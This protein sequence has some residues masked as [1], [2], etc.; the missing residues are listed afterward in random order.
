MN[1]SNEDDRDRAGDARCVLGAGRERPEGAEYRGVEG[2]AE[3][4]PH[5]GP[6]DDAAAHRGDVEGVGE[7]RGHEGDDRRR[8]DLDEPEQADA[9]DLAGEQVAGGHAGEEDLDGAA[10]LLLDDAAEDHGAVGADGE[11]QHHRH[12]EGGGLVVGAAALD[13]AELDVDDRHGLDDG[14]QLLGVH[15]GGLGP[16]ADSDELD[17]T[18]HDRLEL[19]VGARAPVE[20]PCIDH[21]HV[22]VA[23]AYGGSAVG[24]CV[25]VVD[26]DCGVDGVTL[27]LHGAGESRR[28]C[29]G[30]PDVFGAGAGA[31]HGGQ[32]D[33]GGDRQ[34]HH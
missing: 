26:A 17:G 19:L 34:E 7:R 5:D 8:G 27:G 13:L 18:G 25:V 2:V 32:G 22:D 14:E 30:E 20:L 28:C 10:R 9:G 1:A 31:E 11:E 24:A 29:P 15:P 23:V 6:G 4:E 16:V 33:G 12:E 21:Q 3:D